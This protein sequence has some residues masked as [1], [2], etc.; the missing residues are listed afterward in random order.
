MENTSSDVIVLL[1]H[2]ILP[3]RSP[4]NADQQS[5]P[6][7]RLQEHLRALRSAGFECVP[8]EDA[9]RDLV[10]PSAAITSPKFAVTFDDGY[11]SLREYLP[12]LEPDIRPTVF[13]LT[14]YAGKSNLVW[15][16]RSPIIQ[17]HMSFDEARQLAELRVNFELH[18]VDHH[19][20]LKFNREE[21]CSRFERGI[22]QFHEHFGKQPVFL[23]YPYGYCDSTVKE[24]AARYFRGA[25]SVTHGAWRGEEARYAA[26]R[27]S[28]PSYLSGEDLVAVV[29]AEPKRRWLECEM[30]APWRR[31]QT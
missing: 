6:F 2:N 5:I 20:L 28:V 18:G 12:Q 3:P 1:Y 8:L 25:F 21:L 4:L 16:T 29:C 19:N 13:F 31:S 10:E 26:N 15:N 22:A 7:D 23:S 11:E 24:V 30:R 9:F 14:E 17:R 27:L